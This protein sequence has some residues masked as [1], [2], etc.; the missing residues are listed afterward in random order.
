LV[1]SDHRHPVVKK[2]GYLRRHEHFPLSDTEFTHTV[3]A[4]LEI[5]QGC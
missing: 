1:L 3:N 4:A 5:F 2:L